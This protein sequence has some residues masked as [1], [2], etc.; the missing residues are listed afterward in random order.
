MTL[1]EQSRDE[2]R[3]LRRRDAVAALKE[4]LAVLSSR[5]TL[6]SEL[7]DTLLG[8]E[9]GRA[10]SSDDLNRARDI[11][12]SLTDYSARLRL[13]IAGLE[14]TDHAG[15][16]SEF[17][18][19][20]TASIMSEAQSAL[21]A[22]KPILALADELIASY[23]EITAGVRFVQLPLSAAAPEIAHAMLIEIPPDR[24]D[25]SNLWRVE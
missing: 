19:G 18:D 25:Q 23:T 24:P 22:L 2:Q 5:Y 10:I 1:E 7:S 13:A 14:L 21:N 9:K 15:G 16:E 17:D 8:V 4:G 20:E 12:F 3:L 6:L 11:L